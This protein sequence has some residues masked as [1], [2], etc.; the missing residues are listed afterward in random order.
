MADEG[1]MKCV[2]VL[3]YVLLLT[4]CICAVGLIAV[5]IGAK[6]NQ[7]QI[8]YPGVTPESLVPVIII[9]VGV[10]LFLV[11]FVGCYGACKENYCLMITLAICLSLIMLLEVVAVVAGY[12]LKDK[13]ISESNKDFQRQ[14]QNYPKNNHMSL[15]Q[16]RMQEHFKCC[17]AT[18]YTEWVKILLM[19]EQVP[20]SY[21]VSIAEDCG[22][23]FNIE[24]MHA[25]GCVHTGGWLRSKVVIATA[26]SFA[27]M[28][29][30]G[31][32]FACC[33]V[34]SIRSGYDDGRVLLSSARYT[35]R[36]G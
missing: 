23:N 32:V 25:E 16:D 29:V 14:I 1:G 36:M 27:V 6:L 2:K 7:N 18:N 22:I 20:G 17:R 26:L 13:V 21:C 30:L 24:E 5:G 35:R 34:K 3:L 9:A 10:C 19:T 11:A 31:I 33:L 8:I 4:C 28:E 12:M 15:I